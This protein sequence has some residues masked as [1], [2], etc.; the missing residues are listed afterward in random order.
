MSEEHIVT[1]QNEEAM[2]MANALLDD[3]GTPE[4]DDPQEE[5]EVEAA[6]EVD[7]DDSDS[8]GDSEDDESDV[9]EL[10]FVEIEIDGKKYEVPEELK[11]GYLMQADYTRKTQS[12]K[13]YQKEVELQQKTLQTQQKEHEFISEIQPDLN[14]LGYLNAQI[15]QIEQNLQAN[16]NNLPSDELFKMKIQADGLREQANA[17]KT[18][19]ESKYGD[20]QKSQEQAYTELLNQ[21]TEVLKQTIP[22]WTPEKQK[23]VRDFALSQGFNE[24]EVNS[25]V[26]PRHVRVLWAAA[27][28]DRLQQKGPQVA[29]EVTQ[30]IKAKARN[31]MPKATR[32]KLDNRKKLKS[33]NTSDDAKASIIGEEAADWFFGNR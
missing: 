21:G 9:D 25:I 4:Y 16:V 27:E 30:K 6:E 24:A 13:D 1:P 31:P 7:T 20:F 33:K 22:D 8:E 28:Y 12:L 10:R 19:L 23:Q 29:N 5:D 3:Q 18:D 14:N 26:D 32:R 2:D 11:D 17:L 15:Q